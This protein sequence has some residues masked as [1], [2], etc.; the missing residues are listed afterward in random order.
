MNGERS[1]ALMGA[2]ILVILT[3]LA[4]S[5]S[6]APL[7]RERQRMKET[8]LIYR[9]KHW[10]QGIRAFYLRTGR[11]PYHLDEVASLSPRVIR[12]AYTDPMNPEGTWVL[13]PLTRNSF[14]NEQPLG[15]PDE[16]K[17]QPAEG[18][19]IGIHS[20]SDTTGFRNYQGSR[21]YQDWRFTAFVKPP[22]KPQRPLLPP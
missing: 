2:L 16:G 21:L 18:Q 12:K 1:Y 11:F 9:G 6:L 4:L 10:A 7:N 8:L 14:G 15:S 13:I 5:L 20:S 17:Q 3:Q 19:I 22:K